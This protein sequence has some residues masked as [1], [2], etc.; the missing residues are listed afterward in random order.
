MI[1]KSQP[2]YAYQR[3]GFSLIELLVVTTIMIVLTT[4]G[5]VSYAQSTRNARNAKRKSDLEAVRQ[6]LVLYRNDEDL[7]PTCTDA[8]DFTAMLITIDDYI[9][10]D[11]IVDPK[12]PTYDYVYTCSVD[13]RIFELCAILET[14][15]L[16]DIYCIDNP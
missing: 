7:Y 5:L 11:S 14:A 15:T 8:A 12:S 13:G 6:A 1:K 10:F 4:I 16:P 3:T 9:S 2:G